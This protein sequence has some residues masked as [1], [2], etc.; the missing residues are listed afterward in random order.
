[1]KKIIIFGLFCVSLMILGCGDSGNSGKTADNGNDS[2]RETGSLYGECY[3]NETCDKGLECDV[4]NNVC[5]KETEPSN[6]DESDSESENT[7]TI[8]DENNDISDTSS[9]QNDDNADTDSMNFD[10][11]DSNDNSDSVPDDNNLSETEPSE[12]PDSEEDYGKIIYDQ[13]K[14]YSRKCK[15]DSETDS[16]SSYYCQDQTFVWTFSE[17]CP[18]GCN[19]KT[20]KCKIWKDPETNLTWAPK[21]TAFSSTY[22]KA[23][24]YC[25]DLSEGGFNDW[26]MPNIDELRTLALNCSAIETGGSCRISD[27]THCLSYDECYSSENCACSNEY[28]NDKEYSKFHDKGMEW[29]W[30]SSVLPDYSGVIWGI[31]FFYHYN[32]NTLSYGGKIGNLYIK[33]ELSE[34]MYNV[35]CVR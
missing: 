16:Y 7:D 29:Y 35:R 1:M 4:E 25:N 15:Y 10:D 6:S 3:P 28:S 32:G 11:N 27:K 30:S 13:C 22:D 23:K 33:N 12:N 26:R 21:P 18:G 17:Y 8:S 24:E 20:G 2:G 5:L 19:E 9:E 34:G 14:P 31:T